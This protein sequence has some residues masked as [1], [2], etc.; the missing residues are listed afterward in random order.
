MTEVLRLEFPESLDVRKFGKHMSRERYQRG[1]LKK[2]GKH[3]KVWRGRWHVYVRQPDSS[4]KICKREKILGPVADLTR[5]QAQEKLD[6]LIK[7]GTSQITGTLAR[8]TTLKDLWREYR[9]LKSASWSTATRKALTS[10]FAGESG[11]KKRPS[12][13][14]LLGGRLVRD[15]TRG[16]LQDLLN[17]MAGRGDSYSSVKKARTYLSAMFEF[18]RDER[19]IA[20]NPAK[21]LEIPV[22]LLRKPCER[23]YSLEEVRRLLS[24]AHGREHLVLRIFINCGLRPG[25]LFA[26]REDDIETGRLRIDEAVKDTERGTNRVGN[27]KTTGSVA[28]VTMSEGLQEELRMWTEARR[29]KRTYHGVADQASRESKLL[30]PSERG[31]TFRLGNYL[32]R[33]LKP[34][35]EKAGIKDMTYQALRRTCATHFQ[36]FGT[37]RDIQA[38]LRHSRLEMTGRYV[39]EIPDEVRAA[40]E[41][42]DREL[43]PELRPREIQ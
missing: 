23:Y 18:A 17:T 21:K 28:Y 1:S 11:K 7:A 3:R 9:Q 13:L 12:I 5:A 8:E 2:I 14:A 25:E 4:E 26:L 32:K 6:S 35:A 34:L 38:Q 33:H 29:Q 30:F 15:L 20:D 10:V 22:R 36:K 43:C 37:P 39:K 40:V 42:M 31:T 41:N 27:P 19:L 16:P 24:Q